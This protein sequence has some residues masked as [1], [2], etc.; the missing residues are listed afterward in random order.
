[1]MK[2]WIFWLI[3]FCPPAK[4]GDLWLDVNLASKHF[5]DTP[6]TLQDYNERNYGFGFEY[7]FNENYHFIAGEYS[8]SLNN[9]SY[10]AGLG[11]LLKSGGT[12][13]LWKHYEFGAE[14]GVANGYGE[15]DSEDGQH[16]SK[17]NDYILIAGPYLKLGETHAIKIRYAFV[18]ATI[19]YQ[20]QF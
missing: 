5:I 4:A 20:Y 10:Y 6:G 17:S 15:F 7:R 8:N 3:L 2:K 11:R 13:Y 12:D 16:W 9:Q 1:M 18:L 14:M 19:G